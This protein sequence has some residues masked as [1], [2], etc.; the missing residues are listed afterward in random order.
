MRFMIWLGGWLRSLR[1]RVWIMRLRACCI[2]GT[3]TPKHCPK[4]GST[5]IHNQELELDSVSEELYDVYC[6]DC[7]WSGYI[8]PDLSFSEKA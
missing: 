7:G 6:R 5:N 1:V 4:C 3:L 2:M 8:S